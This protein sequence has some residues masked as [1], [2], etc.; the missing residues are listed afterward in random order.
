VPLPHRAAPGVTEGNTQACKHPAGQPSPCR[1]QRCQHTGLRQ[2]FC[3]L[4]S[5]PMG[6]A[7][8]VHLW[9]S[10]PVLPGTCVPATSW[11]PMRLLWGGGEAASGASPGVGPQP[12]PHC[13]VTPHMG[14]P[15]KGSAHPC[16]PGCYGKSMRPHG[17]SAGLH[18]ATK[19]VPDTHPSC[20]DSG[21]RSEQQSPPLCLSLPF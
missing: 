3:A 1:C 6:T 7:I 11:A 5:S 20:W 16:W 18:V 12:S 15:L 21:H 2:P 17:C 19:T 13:V 14:V 4:A 9:L 10:V 8:S